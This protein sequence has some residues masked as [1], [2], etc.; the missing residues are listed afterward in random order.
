[1][2]P[3]MPPKRR[4]FL[5]LLPDIAGDSPDNGVSE[6]VFLAHPR[7]QKHPCLG[8]PHPDIY[9]EMSVSGTRKS[10]IYLP[11][12][13]SL[14]LSPSIGQWGPGLHTLNP[15][16]HR[17]HVHIQILVWPPKGPCEKNP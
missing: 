6:A 11:P 12:K 13:P 14:P 9:P 16:S 17:W 5:R 1:M 2:Q 4:F 10:E 15:V 3:G 8:Q 7:G